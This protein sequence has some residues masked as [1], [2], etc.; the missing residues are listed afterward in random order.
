MDAQ[1][2]RCGAG[3]AMIESSPRVPGHPKA[4]GEK[5]VQGPGNNLQATVQTAG[6]GFALLTKNSQDDL[7]R[8]AEI[9]M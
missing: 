4:T 6:P 7:V 3:K 9:L 1:E 8:L 2:Q 5:R